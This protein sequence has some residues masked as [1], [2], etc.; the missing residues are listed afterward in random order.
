MTKDFKIGLLL[1][2]VIVS[3]AGIWLCVSPTVSVRSRLGNL[4]KSKITNQAEEWQIAPAADSNLKN[5]QLR[6]EQNQTI[7]NETAKEIPTEAPLREDEITNIQLNKEDI[8]IFHTVRKDE[9]LSEIALR[10]YGSANKWT[11]IRDANPKVDPLKLKPGT[12]LII[13]P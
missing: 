7:E 3:I 6:A 4:Q 11:K 13:P 9:T 2:L 8:T 12:T 5:A 10:Y 1:G